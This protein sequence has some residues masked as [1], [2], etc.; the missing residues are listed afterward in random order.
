MP[1]ARMEHWIS[2]EASAEVLQKASV[3]LER[4]VLGAMLLLHMLDK[5]AFPGEGHAAELAAIGF[6]ARVAPHVADEGVFLVEGHGAEGAGEGPI[7]RVDADVPSQMPL[8]RKALF[9]V[10][11][12]V[13]AYVDVGEVR[14]YQLDITLVDG[15]W[16]TPARSQ[17]YVCSR[18]VSR[19]FDPCG[20]FFDCPVPRT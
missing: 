6:V 5:G 18:W 12:L 13:G 2:C 1:L 14:V 8:V 10:R 3:E 20:T 17:R 19:C 4:N 7:A 16:R 9:A 15:P 11:A